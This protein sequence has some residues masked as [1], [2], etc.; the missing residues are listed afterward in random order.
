[1]PPGRQ[2]TEKPTSKG[3]GTMLRHRNSPFYFQ[4]WGLN[5]KSN[6]TIMTIRKVFYNAFL[7]RQENG[8]NV[9]DKT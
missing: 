8:K 7:G 1:M 4:R 6:C 9:L 2:T 3:E 5:S